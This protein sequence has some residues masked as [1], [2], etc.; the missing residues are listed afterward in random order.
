M[1]SQISMK[2]IDCFLMQWEK[3]AY[4]KPCQKFASTEFA[5]R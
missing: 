5:N 1:K 2:K 4:T 3:N